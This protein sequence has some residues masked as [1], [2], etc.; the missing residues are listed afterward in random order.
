MASGA[1][2]ALRIARDLARSNA[3]AAADL[4]ATGASPSRHFL[5]ELARAT[6]RYAGMPVLL[7]SFGVLTFALLSRGFSEAAVVGA[8]SS[9]VFW[10]VWALERFVPYQTKWNARDG[11]L[12]NDIGH[13]LFGTYFGGFLG[14]AA[15][16]ALVGAGAGFIADHLG[17]GLWPTSLPLFVQVALVF[18]VADLGRYVQHR[19]MHAVP[20]LWRFHQLHHATEV[21][22][23]WKTSR[24][25]ILE[26]FTQQLVLFGPVLLLGAPKAV[27][28]P[29]IVVNGMLGIF[30]HSN[31][32]FRLGPLDYVLMTPEAHRIHHSR[33]LVE[34]NTN[35]GTALLVWDFLFGTYTPPAARAKAGLAKVEVGIAADDTPDGFVAQVLD[36]FVRRTPRR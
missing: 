4:E 28:L 9:A 35:F 18:L 30:D 21:M 8:T 36:P 22:S 11:Q 12:A 32:D 27:V 25:H 33:D 24:N 20:F 1:P 7:V 3:V 10:I 23:V 15:T 14:N 31:V 29:F 6:V 17:A 5:V 16:M 19:A 13:L 26:R 34:G 2:T